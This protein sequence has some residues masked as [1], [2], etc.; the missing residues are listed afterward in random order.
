MAWVM[1][2]TVA[3]FMSATH[4]G[5]GSNPSLGAAGAK[6]GVPRLSNALASWPL[7]SIMLVK[8]YFMFVGAQRLP[9]LP[10]SVKAPC[11]WEKI[12]AEKQ[13]FFSLRKPLRKNTSRPSGG[14]RRV[15]CSVLL[16]ATDEEAVFL[17]VFPYIFL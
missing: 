17:W 6:P 12:S 13:R 4:M 9:P 8:S 5:M 16:K 14:S 15:T 3:K 10:Y 7:R 1:V 11:L 2:G